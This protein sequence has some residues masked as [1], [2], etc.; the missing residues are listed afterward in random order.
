MQGSAMKLRGVSSGGVSGAEKGNSGTSGETSGSVGSDVSKK[1][2]VDGPEF[3][4]SQL[5]LGVNSCRGGMREGSMYD[6]SEASSQKSLQTSKKVPNSSEDHLELTLGPVR[7]ASSSQRPKTSERNL[8]PG[9]KDE[10]L[11]KFLSEAGLFTYFPLLNDAWVD[12]D[13]LPQLSKQELMLIG[14][15]EEACKQLRA[16]I[17][18][19]GPRE[20]KELSTFMESLGLSQ[21]THVL[22]KAWV[23]LKE[24][25]KMELSELRTIGIPPGPAQRLL[26]G[27]ARFLG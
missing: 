5:S 6:N 4:G 27:I 8:V 10:R 19:T 2:D 24:L 15:P 12:F 20:D 9:Q 7:S 1:M 22:Q 25:Q 21:F 3:P 16:A 18:A 14:I 17:K 23:D 26:R 13:E 11:E